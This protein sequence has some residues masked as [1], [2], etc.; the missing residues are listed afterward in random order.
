MNAVILI[1]TAF[2]IF[3]VETYPDVN[4]NVTDPT[5]NKTEFEKILG[6]E[7]TE[8]H[9]SILRWICEAN[10]GCNKRGSGI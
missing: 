2:L 9:S 6:I 5:Y 3:R 8:E 7:G 1:I 4:K 10:A